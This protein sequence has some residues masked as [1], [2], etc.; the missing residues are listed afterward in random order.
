MFTAEIINYSNVTQNVYVVIDLE[1][2]EAKPDFTST[3]HVLAV[4]TCDGKGMAIHPE[5][6]KKKFALTSQPMMVQKDG[7]MFGIREYYTFI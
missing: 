3:W 4:G 6:G 1:Y 7:Y 2:L 5:E